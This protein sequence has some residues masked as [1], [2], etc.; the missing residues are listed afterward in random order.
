MINLVL[1]RRVH[2]RRVP[3]HIVSHVQERLLRL[4]ALHDPSLQRLDRLLAARPVALLRL[5][6]DLLGVGAGAGGGGLLGGSGGRFLLLRGGSDGVCGRGGAFD[7]GGGGCGSR[8]RPLGCVG[9]LG[10]AISGLRLLI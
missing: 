9:V 10:L 3:R 5:D 2:E 4:I 6:Q 8:G 7:G 1:H